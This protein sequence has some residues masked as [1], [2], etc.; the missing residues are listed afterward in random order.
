MRHPQKVAKKTIGLNLC[1]YYIFGKT[2]DP[3]EWG[4]YWGGGGGWRKGEGLN[5]A[6]ERGNF[7]PSSSKSVNRAPS[8]KG[9]GRI[10]FINPVFMTP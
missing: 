4:W 2:K 6:I 3:L 9:P 1:H 10:S 5:Q 8:L 7:S